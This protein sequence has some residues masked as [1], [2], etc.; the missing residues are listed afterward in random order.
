MILTEAAAGSSA[1]G[2]I[3]YLPYIGMTGVALIGAAVTVWN[4]RRGATENKAPSVPD[5]WNRAEQAN[6]ELDIERS[7]RRWFQDAFYN[8]VREVLAYIRRIRRGGS[9]EPHA[10]L[11]EALEATPP[12]IEQETP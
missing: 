2:I 8:L 4:R 3:P 5:A 9:T 11:T 1:E 10:A 12:K 6:A 7:L